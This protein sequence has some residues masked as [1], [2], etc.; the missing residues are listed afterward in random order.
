[1]EFIVSVKLIG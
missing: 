1:V